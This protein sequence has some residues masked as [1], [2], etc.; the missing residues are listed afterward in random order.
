MHVLLDSQLN[1][2]VRQ[3]CYYYCCIYQL[4]EYN[5]GVCRV[6]HILLGSC[7]ENLRRCA[8]KCI[9]LILIPISGAV[10]GVNLLCVK[11]F[12]LFD[13]HMEEERVKEAGKKKHALR[14]MKFPTHLFIMLKNI[15]NIVF[16]L[17]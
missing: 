17:L 2:N 15:G 6:Q 11:I 5:S 8:I 14:I 13:L 4:G 16:R 10:R 1:M 9:S 12:A 3:H 7:S